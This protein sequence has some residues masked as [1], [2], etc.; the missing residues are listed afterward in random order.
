MA[1]QEDEL[2][3]FCSLVSRRAPHGNELAWALRRF[4]MGCER[5]SP[6]EA[7]TDHLLAL[8]ALLEPEGAASGRLSGRLAALCATPENRVELTERI[9]KAI[10]I[11]HAAVA[12]GAVVRSGA[13]TLAREVG[14]HLRALLRDVICGH[15]SPDLV[16]LADELLLAE[17]QPSGEELVGDSGEPEEILDLLV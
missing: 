5:E 15:L 2:R 3:A 7:L 10:E 9:V 17:G 4:E 16:G 1:E 13:H 12:G 14:D 8:R 6:Y 11:E